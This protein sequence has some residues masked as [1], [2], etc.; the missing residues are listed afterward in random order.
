MHYARLKHPAP[1]LILLFI[2]VY[3]CTPKAIIKRQVEPFIKNLE[4]TYLSEQD[5]ALVAASFPTNLKLIDA[6][7][8]TRP[9]NSDLLVLG[10][11]SYTMYA[12]G[13]VMEDAD[14][15]ILRDYQAGLAQYHRAKL[16]FERAFNYGRRALELKHVDMDTMLKTHDPSMNPFTKDDVPLLYWSAA[17]LGGQISASQGDPKIV[18]RLPEVVWLLERALELDPDWNQGSLYSAMISVSLSRPDV[19]I[20]GEALARE[21]FEKA[22]NASNGQEAAVFVTLAEKVSVKNQD[23]KEFHSLLDRALAI[24][25]DSTPDNRLANVIA[26]NRARWL[27]DREEELFY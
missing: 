21:Y 4:Y 15:L 18:I 14:R 9:D 23:R 25:V 8:A 27:L 7:I 11:S 16:L 20:K 5:P 1:T 22:V 3:N 13:F 2:F 19:G 17:A 24:N 12:Y 10:A 26:Q 6:L